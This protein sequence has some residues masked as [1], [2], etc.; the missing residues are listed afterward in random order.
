M[1]FASSE[2]PYNKHRNVRLFI[3]FIDKISPS[4]ELKMT[5]IFFIA[6]G[7]PEEVHDFFFDVGGFVIY[8]VAVPIIYITLAA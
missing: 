8:C 6:S 5:E 1:S 7:T 3:C 2:L 4:F